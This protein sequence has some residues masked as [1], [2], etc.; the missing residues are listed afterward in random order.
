MAALIMASTRSAQH[1]GTTPLL[2]HRHRSEVH[3]HQ[4]WLEFL[5][6][7]YKLGDALHPRRG[8]CALHLPCISAPPP[9]ATAPQLGPA[10]HHLGHSAAAGRNATSARP[11]RTSRCSANQAL[12]R[13]GPC[14][15]CQDSLHQRSPKRHGQ[16]SMAV[17]PSAQSAATSFGQLCP[18]CNGESVLPSR[19]YPTNRAHWMI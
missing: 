16:C 19:S 11:S 2:P 14:M 15:A 13:A 5:C 7:A 17:C 12:H 1:L 18:L 10:S 6:A 3:P 8:E 4:R 9:K